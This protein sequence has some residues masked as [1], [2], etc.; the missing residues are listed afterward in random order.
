MSEDE[1]SSSNCLI[2]CILEDILEDI[3][4]NTLEKVFENKIENIMEKNVLVPKGSWINSHASFEIKDNT[5]YAELYDEKGIKQLKSITIHKDFTYMNNN[6]NFDI[7]SYSNTLF[8]CISNQLGNCLRVITS[9]MIIAEYYNMHVFID[10]DKNNLIYKDKLVI[11]YLFP[12]ICQKNIRQKYTELKYDNYVYYPRLY[13]TNYHLIREGK[14]IKPPN[15]DNFG[16]TFNIYNIIPGDMNNDDFIRK[17]IKIYKSLVFPDFLMSDVSNFLLKNDLSQFIGFHI[18]YTDNLVDVNK[19]KFNTP[20]H[21]F[22]QKLESYTNKNIFICS[23]NTNII[24]IIKNK[25][26]KK[27][28]IVFPD[29]CSLNFYQ[30]LYEM[31]LL[32]K[33][34]LIIG[35]N[36]SSFSYESAF[37]E[38]TDIEFFEN[39]KW[40]LYKLSDY[41]V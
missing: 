41:K 14:F 13:R 8:V 26:N 22:F 24:N 16:I 28:N 4:E 25:K 11:E 30:H 18:R 17:K 32:S 23:D 39:N 34:S 7:E 6:G 29:K 21:V 36:S 9:C 15:I 20:I 27:N 38:G 19:K 5:L 10:M 3:L 31:I 33:T 37:F 12:K 35:S 2:E 40:N 1:K